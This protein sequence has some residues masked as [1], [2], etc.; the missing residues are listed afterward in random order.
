MNHFRGAAADGAAATR[1]AAWCSKSRRMLSTQGI[2]KRPGRTRTRTCWPS[3]RSEGVTPSRS[4]K[5]RMR[6]MPLG[7]SQAR[8][9]AHHRAVF[10]IPHTPRIWLLCSTAGRESNVPL[11]VITIAH[12]QKSAEAPTI[13]PSVM[14]VARDT[15]RQRRAARSTSR[16]AATA[17]TLPT[18]RAKSQKSAWPERKPSS[19]R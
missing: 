12:A 13:A 8:T 15:G 2:P 9:S 1:A 4:G 17:A 16:M 10:G 3:S 5:T 14:A 7:A 6:L 11:K 19:V 18:A